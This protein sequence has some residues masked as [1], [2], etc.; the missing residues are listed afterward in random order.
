MPTGGKMLNFSTKCKL[1][2]DRRRYKIGDRLGAD[3]YVYWEGKH[4]I[5]FGKYGCVCI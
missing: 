3:N 5:N 4:V 2:R 1:L